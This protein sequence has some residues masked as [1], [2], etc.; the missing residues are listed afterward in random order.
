MK[1]Q[2]KSYISFSRTERAGLIGL[3][4]VLIILIAI[5]ATMH[6][7]VHPAEG[8]S[9][10][11]KLEA[12]WQKF[13]NEHPANSKN[14][15]DSSGNNTVDKI[16]IA[17]HNIDTN[18]IVKKKSRDYEDALDDN[19]TPM[20]DI[21]NINT[22]DSTTLVRLKGIGPATAAKIIARRK[23]QGPFT[24]VDQLLKVRHIPDATFKILRQH[25]TVNSSL[26]R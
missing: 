20:P 4:A 13:K 6:L 10:N 15:D 21:I 22:A 12:A 26:N 23:E 24:N 2:L 1:K 19:E 3:C 25:L 5:R 11:T 14:E 8:V 18:P 7:W 9:K 16:S 17:Y